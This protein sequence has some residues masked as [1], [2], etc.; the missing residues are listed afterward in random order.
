MTRIKGQTF[1][2]KR[3]VGSNKI[4]GEEFQGEIHGEYGR[5]SEMRTRGG[6]RRRVELGNDFE[7]NKMVD[8]AD[9]DLEG[10]HREVIYDRKEAVKNRGGQSQ[11]GR[12][13]EQNP[14]AK[15]DAKTGKS[16][17]IS[18]KVEHRTLLKNGGFENGHENFG[19]S[20]QRF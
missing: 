4:L 16:H 13:S 1:G 17:S 10:I 18:T 6:E 20:R 11:T 2:E 19:S 5:V 15:F 14:K 9:Q 12:Y 8:E 7:P 3:V